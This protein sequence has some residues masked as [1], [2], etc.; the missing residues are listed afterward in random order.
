MNSQRYIQNKELKIV[1][2]VGDESGIGP[3][4]ILKALS[5][6]EI[7]KNITISIVGSKINFQF[8]SPQRYPR[9]G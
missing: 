1:I 3:E 7:P 5:S 2:S 6:E 8:P 9:V 4:I